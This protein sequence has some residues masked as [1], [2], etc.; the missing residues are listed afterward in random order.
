MYGLS[1]KR[2]NELLVFPRQPE[3]DNYNHKMV[4]ARNENTLIFAI[5][6]LLYAYN[7]LHS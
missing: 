7:S 5:I 3:L 4:F 1:S 2:S 6:Y